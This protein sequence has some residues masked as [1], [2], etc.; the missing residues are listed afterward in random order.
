ME[1]VNP[2]SP[3]KSPTSPI[4]KRVLELKKLIESLDIVVPPLL[5]NELDEE[6][7]EEIKEEEGEVEELGVEYFDNFP[8]SDELAYH[9]HNKVHQWNRKVAYQMP[10]KIEQYQL[11]SN[12]K[13][14]HLQS[15]YFRSEDDKRKGVDYVMKKMLGFYKECLELGPEYKVKDDGV[16]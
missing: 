5:V 16:T 7:E 12:L 1:N 2:P 11:V 8:T 14:D 13:K 6:V 9:K 10:H 15:V 4:S 3:P